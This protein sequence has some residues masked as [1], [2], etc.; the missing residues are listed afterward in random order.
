MSL[1][2][3]LISLVILGIAALLLWPPLGDGREYLPNDEEV[4][5]LRATSVV[6]DEKGR[7][8]FGRGSVELRGGLN[9]LKL[10]GSN[11]EMGYQ[12]G[13]LLAEEIRQGAVPCFAK[14]VNNFAPFKHM[15][16]IMRFATQ[17]YFDWKIFRPLMKSTPLPYLS[18][19]KGL[20]DA[21][22]MA[23]ADVFRGNMYSELNMNLI[24]VLEKKALQ[25]T[26]ENG[27]TSFAA[28]GDATVDGKLIMGRN[29]D[30]AGGG[31][32]D[33]YQIVMFYGPEE[34]YRFVNVSSAGLIKCNSCMN[35]KGLC[36]G[37]HFLFLNDT[38]AD[39]VAFT[40][41][42]LEIMKKASTIDEAVTIIRENARAGAFAFL[43]ADG[44]TN[45]AAVIEVSAGRVGV[46][47]AEGN[48][49]WETNM[50]T[51][52]EIEPVDV[53]LRND[54]GK[55]PIARFER[56]RMLL[57]E[58]MGSITPDLA[59]KFMGDH[60]DM[61][62][63]S[64]RPAGGI[65]SQLT[66]VTSAVFSPADFEFWVA[67]GLSPVCN[68]TF[69]GFNLMDELADGESSVE[70]GVLAPNDYVKTED[71]KALRKY[72]EAMVSFT[73][74]PTDEKAAFNMLEEAIALKPEE[75][76]YRRT[77]AKILLRQADASAAEEHLNRALECVQ[78]PSERAQAHLLIGFKEDLLGRRDNALNCYDEVVKIA[79][80]SNGDALS[81]V[82][83]FVVAN[84]KKYSRAPFT[85]ETAKKIEINFDITS[86][87]DL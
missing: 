29:T 19:L 79:E 35:E 66:N 63:D 46:R 65:V 58:N 77:A 78:S 31:L 37:G 24:K 9:V 40:F 42:E 69:T 48:V 10:H 23:F 33:K 55:N 85:S 12:H 4:R 5:W 43:V 28:F 22:G 74:P 6:E 61:C 11:Y 56:M 45:E 62:S 25:K 71:Y 36:L 15:N 39:G 54:I 30:Y 49:V 84:A 26:G 7:K 14:A 8:A 68:N 52:E 44:K 47:R 51:T 3:I 81:C 16:G 13:V 83:R 60:M 86:M 27:C 1:I 50:A 72:Y 21:T 18:E 53:F 70:P 17:K 2:I 73:I 57:N 41:F 67:D 76:I 82:N 59:A 20:A 34:G 75:A 38:R 87:Y 32:W 80:S 64:M